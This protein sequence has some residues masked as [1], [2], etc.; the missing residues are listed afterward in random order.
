MSELVGVSTRLR[1]TDR[2]MRGLLAAATALAIVPLALILYYLLKKGLGAWG[3]SFFTSDPN[4]N[5]LGDPG[6]VKNPPVRSS[7][8]SRIPVRPSP[9]GLPT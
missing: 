9:G 3:S 1:Q 7:I 2:V 4:G 6:G 8:Y 5:F